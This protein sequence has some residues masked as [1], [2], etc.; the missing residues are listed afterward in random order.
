MSVNPDIITWAR[1]RAG[2]KPAD[3][4]LLKDFPRLEDWESGNTRPTYPQLE[5]LA[6]KLKVPLSVFYFPERPELPRIEET[7]RTIG[8]DVIQDIPPKI[9]LLL[10]KARAFQIGL[11]ELNDGRNPAA[12][13]IT[14]DL[15]PR[16]GASIESIAADV[17]EYIGVSFETQF[18]WRN[19][20]LAFKGWRK[21]FYDCGVYV[22]KDAFGQENSDYSG[23]CIHNDEFP[24]I[25]V[26]NS[27]ARTRQIF[28]LFHE[29]AHLLFST[30]GVD[31]ETDDFIS[32]LEG[33]P[34]RIEILC[35][36]LASKVLVPDDVF[37]GEY[38][39]LRGTR[40]VSDDPRELAA[41]LANHFGVSREMIY[42]KLLD[43]SL[44][45]QEEYVD[46]ARV[47]RGQQTSKGSGG[48]MYYNWI[49]YLGREYISLAF[50]RYYQNQITFEQLGDYL[51]IKPKNLNRLEDYLVRSS[52]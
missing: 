45:S 47:W 37:G 50:R 38:D 52:A 40:R 23:F 30:S 35:N 1:E 7:F 13:V 43:R 25:F 6:D 34:H 3:D 14:H 29:L 41:D 27:A 49:T 17:R 42:R 18:A 5:R 48:N 12:R 36:R 16:V 32:E 24:V 31:T 15:N 39:A 10:R 51:D 28:T 33:D 21:A 44:I 4:R 20:D 19:S 8:V 11:D 22:F 9:R 46:A 26:N 2:Y